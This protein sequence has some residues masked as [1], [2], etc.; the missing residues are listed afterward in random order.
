MVEKYKDHPAVYGLEPVNEPWEFT[1]I[2][3][4]KRYYW[5]GYLIVKESAPDWKYVIHDSFRL[6][7][8]IWGGFMSGC[9]DRAMDTHIY[10]AWNFPTSRENFYSDA[11]AQKFRI[12]SIEQTFGPVIV[13]EWSL[14]TECVKY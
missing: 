5:N 11:C 13:G 8:N 1:P 2:D 9:P 3:K 4:L 7:P 10:Q 6:D 12:A 14:A